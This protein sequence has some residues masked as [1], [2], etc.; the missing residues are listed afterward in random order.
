MNN[1][2]V[3]HIDKTGG[4]SVDLMLKNAFN[5]AG[6]T[7][8][9]N[10]G[11]TFPNTIKSKYARIG[12]HHEYNPNII[13]DNWTK[14]LIIRKPLDRFLS[15]YNY[16]I[17]EYWRDTGKYIDYSVQDFC[18]FTTQRLSGYVYPEQQQNLRGYINSMTSLNAEQTCGFKFTNT[19]VFNVFDAVIDT[20]CLYKLK[21]LLHPLGLNVN[22]DV[23]INFAGQLMPT[24]KITREQDLTHTDLDCINEL[25]DYQQ[26]LELWKLYNAYTS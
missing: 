24:L 18:K 13:N 16:F 26:E 15:A 11:S 22:T 12:M 5:S 17:S 20:S 3:P 6:W 1:L 23:H 7:Y 8:D 21:D 10:A 9:H 14:I 4:Q 19:N 25:V 2:Y